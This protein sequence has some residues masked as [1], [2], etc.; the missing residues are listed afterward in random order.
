VGSYRNTE[1]GELRGEV[2]MLS[3]V[4]VSGGRSKLDCRDTSI[5]GHDQLHS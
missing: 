1:S 4:G 5:G 2:E 3:R